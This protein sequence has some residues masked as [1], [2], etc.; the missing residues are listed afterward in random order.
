MLKAGYSWMSNKL[1]NIIKKGIP[2]IYNTIAEKMTVSTWNNATFMQFHGDF[3]NINIS[4]VSAT[5]HLKSVRIANGYWSYYAANYLLSLSVK[6][7]LVLFTHA[8]L[9]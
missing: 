5:A 4:Q 6:Q 2:R 7:F 9:F 3:S 1:Y 8:T